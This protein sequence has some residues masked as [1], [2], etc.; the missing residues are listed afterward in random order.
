VGEEMSCLFIGGHFDGRKMFIPQPL[1][2]VKLPVPVQ[3]T[4]YSSFKTEEYKLMRLCGDGEDF[5]LYCLIELD[6]GDVLRNLI[7][8][9]KP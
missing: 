8:H 7:K 6:A 4:D 9:Y 3:P 5:E 2:L 1:P